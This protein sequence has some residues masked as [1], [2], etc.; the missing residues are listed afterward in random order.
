MVINIRFVALSV[1]VAKTDIMIPISG[2]LVLQY[3]FQPLQIAP[4]MLILLLFQSAVL[5]VPTVTGVKIRELPLTVIAK[6]QLLA[7][8]RVRPAKAVNFT[9][10]T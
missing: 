4:V 10:W 1:A 2:L 7:C 6:P 3:V 9:S 8:K 5:L